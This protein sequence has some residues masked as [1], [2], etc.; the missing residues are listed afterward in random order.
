MRRSRA[1]LY[2]SVCSTANCGNKIVAGVGEACSLRGMLELGI[3]Q[4][5][6]HIRAWVAESTAEIDLS[7]MK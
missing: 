6:D 2:L 1:Y 5:K 4:V 7:G 3:T